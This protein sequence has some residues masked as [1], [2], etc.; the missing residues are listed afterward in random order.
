MGSVWPPLS[1][2]QLKVAETNV[3]KLTKAL[4]AALEEAA[5]ASLSR[6]RIAQE[7]A[8]TTARLEGCL[9]EQLAAAQKEHQVSRGLNACSSLTPDSIRTTK[10]VCRTPR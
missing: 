6:E 1:A 7:M 2:A 4:E 3:D 5:T 8:D 10:G 9:V